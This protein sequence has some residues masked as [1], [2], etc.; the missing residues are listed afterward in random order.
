MLEPRADLPVLSRG[1]LAAARTLVLTPGLAF[2]CRGG[3]LGRGKGYYDRFF[4]SL[5]GSGRI[6]SSRPV[7]SAAAGEGIQGL[8]A[9][10]VCFTLQIVDEVPMGEGDRRVDGIVTEEGLIGLKQ[11]S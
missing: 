3:R 6:P 9:W 4:R 7:Q 2:D 5:E 10:G 11:S 1:E 8:P